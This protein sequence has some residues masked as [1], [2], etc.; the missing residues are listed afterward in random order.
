MYS[1]FPQDRRKCRIVLG[2]DRKA[3][4]RVPTIRARRDRLVSRMRLGA[5]VVASLL[6]ATVMFAVPGPS[7]SAASCTNENRCGMD[8]T[9]AWKHYTKGDPHVLVSYIEGGINWHLPVAK[10]LNDRIFVN[11]HETPVPCW[12]P[13]K[14]RCHRHYSKYRV[15][16][17]INRDGFVNAADWA[18]DPRVHDS[19]DN[20][21]IDAEDLIA[22]FSTKKDRDHNGYRSDISGWDFYDRQ[23]DPATYEATYDHSDDQMSVVH[24]YCPN[25]MIVPIKAGAE[26]LDRTNDLA[27]A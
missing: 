16:Y 20:G 1:P 22:A 15:D 13:K 17:D 6:T 14:S 10:T 2:H 11:W 18:K 19:N 12:A 3:S 26:A 25:C 9:R 27:Q 8:I 21:Y 4:P 24:H 7:A 5:G 23:N